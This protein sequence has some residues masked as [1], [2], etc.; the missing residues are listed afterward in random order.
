MIG[1]FSQDV[2]EMRGRSALEEVMAGA[3][4]VSTL[5]VE[6]QPNQTVR[7]SLDFAPE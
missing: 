1:Y 2:G 7:K 4:K 5:A 6:I 3:G